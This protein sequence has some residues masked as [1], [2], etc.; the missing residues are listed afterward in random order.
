MWH[1][2]KKIIGSSIV[3]QRAKLQL[4]TPAFLI[5]TSVAVP[6]AQLLIQLSPNVCEKAVEG[7]PAT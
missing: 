4:A 3:E 7:C 2:K 6:V 5:I 1:I